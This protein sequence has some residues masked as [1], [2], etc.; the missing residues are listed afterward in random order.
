MAVTNSISERSL[1][2]HNHEVLAFKDCVNP[3]C[4]HCWPPGPICYASLFGVCSS[5]GNNSSFWTSCPKKPFMEKILGSLPMAIPASI[6]RDTNMD[7][8]KEDTIMSASTAGK[9]QHSQE[10]QLQTHLLLQQL[11]V[12]FSAVAG[13][14]GDL[15]HHS[16]SLLV[17]WCPLCLLSFN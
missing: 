17:A 7:F 15:H 6:W 4:E 16:L 10:N 12:K 1:Y 2:I 9:S 11:R 13:M 8:E 14:A 3:S 5:S